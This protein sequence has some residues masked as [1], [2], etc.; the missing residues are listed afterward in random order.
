MS[1]SA[2]NPSRKH[3]QSFLIGLRTQEPI[4]CTNTWKQKR[5]GKKRVTSFLNRFHEFLLDDAPSK[6]LWPWERGRNLLRS[7]SHSLANLGLA[8][9]LFCS[10]ND[11]FDRVWVSLSILTCLPN[12][13]MLMFPDLRYSCLTQIQH[14]RRDLLPPSRAELDHFSFSHTPCGKFICSPEC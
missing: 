6:V 10:G 5:R 2:A 12:K 3:S 11:I 9:S 7:D 13:M 8:T 4:Y 14:G 1:W